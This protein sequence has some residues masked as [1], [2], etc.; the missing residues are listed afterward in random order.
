MG[1]KEETYRGFQASRMFEEED[2]L[3]SKE[4]VR[5]Y[6]QYKT[7]DPS[8]L[9][10][11]MLGDSTYFFNELA[12]EKLGFSADANFHEISITDDAMLSYIRNNVDPNAVNILG[13]G[14]SD[15]NNKPVSQNIYKIKSLI[16]MDEDT[17]K[18][19]VFSQELVF[20]EQC[21]YSVVYPYYKDEYG[22]LW[23]SNDRNA[24]YN[25]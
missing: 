20:G 4:M 10:P 13:Y 12:F 25:T 2:N 9:L 3:F 1:S 18:T 15:D 19:K 5:L 8:V 22:D 7:L 6:A 14:L 21:T 17:S 24:S 11:L 16:T 23:L